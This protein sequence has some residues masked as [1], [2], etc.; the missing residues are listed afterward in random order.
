MYPAGL[1]FVFSGKKSGSNM[2]GLYCIT[3][4][5]RRLNLIKLPGIPISRSCLLLF[6]KKIVIYSNNVY[7]VYNLMMPGVILFFYRCDIPA[8]FSLLF[9]V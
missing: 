2:R 9:D 4:A 3:V 1:T 8:R 7:C 6:P 5:F